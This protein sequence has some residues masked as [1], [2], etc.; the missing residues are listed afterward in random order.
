MRR[1]ILSVA[2]VAAASLALVGTAEAG[3]QG[4]SKGGG[5]HMSSSHGSHDYHTSHGSKMKDGSYS[6]K[7]RDHHQW[8]YQCWSKKYGCQCYYCPSTCCWYY[9]YAPSCCYYPCSYA[10]T[11]PPTPCAAPAGC[12]SGVTQVVN[13]TN[14]SPGAA[15]PAGPAPPA[16]PPLRGRERR[17]EANRPGPLDVRGRAGSLAR[18]DA[19]ADREPIAV[20]L[21]EPRHLGPF[22]KGQPTT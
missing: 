4:G 2:V 8:T 22:S 5:S 6:Y 7:G 13:V 9:W 20:C 19:S 3:P 16:L 14:N 10:P 15:A 18:P 12:P 21:G 17:P 1:F 11:C